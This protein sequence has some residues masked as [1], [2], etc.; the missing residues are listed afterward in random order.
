MIEFSNWCYDPNLSARQIRRYN[1]I[2][3]CY[4]SYDCNQIP[5]KKQLKE[6]RVY[7]ALHFELILSS[8]ARKALPLVALHS[9]CVHVE[10]LSSTYLGQAASGQE[11]Q[12]MKHQCQTPLITSS[13]KAQPSQASTT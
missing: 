9:G 12:V 2:C 3:V 1:S 11:V 5:S 10:L 13:N 7:F 4:F 8:V 6:G